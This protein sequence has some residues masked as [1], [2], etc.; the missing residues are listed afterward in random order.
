MASLL[1]IAVLTP[2][3]GDLLRPYLT[4]AIVGLLSIAF[5]R[6]DMKSFSSHIRQPAL[7]FKATL[8]T[9]LAIPALITSLCLLAGINS[10]S[11]GLYT[12]LLLQAAASPMMAAPAIAALLP[13]WRCSASSTT[14][15]RSA[16]LTCS[17]VSAIGSQR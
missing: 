4:L 16:S 13:C 17:A 15:S 12:A 14:A 6:I 1:L 7:V 8:W 9:M 10:I 3:L 2:P 11:A 5:L